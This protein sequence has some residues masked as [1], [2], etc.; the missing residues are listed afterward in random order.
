[1][2]SVLVVRNAAVKV[3]LAVHNSA[4]QIVYNYSNQQSAGGQTYSIPMKQWSKGVYYVTVRLNDKKEIT[5]KLIH[6]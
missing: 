5:K 2:L 6:Q 3:G 4:G 1:M